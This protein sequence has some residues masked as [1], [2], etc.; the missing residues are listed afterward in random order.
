MRF[1][2]LQTLALLAARESG[3]LLRL[4]RPLRG[5]PRVL[6]PTAWDQEYSAG[7]WQFLDRLSEEAHHLVI[8]SYLSGLD[9]AERIL[10]VGC[11]EGY[12]T[13]VL[14]KFRYGQYIGIDTSSVAIAA[15]Q[16]HADAKTRFQAV[17]GDEYTTTD[18]FDAIVFNETLNYFADPVGTIEHFSKFL[19]K[20][21]VFV[22][23]LSL[24]GFRNGILK[25]GIWQDI[26]ARLNVRD[27]TTIYRPDG[28][29]WIV[30]VLTPAK[31]AQTPAPAEARQLEDA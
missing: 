11:G 17:P 28:T 22:I 13:P 27:E 10:D 31:S 7:K 3:L 25:L 24:V 21:G 14:R 26:Q 9:R 1:G 8:A 20:D 29:A 15:A 30:K 16:R 5:K 6:S 19:A 4:L 12:F 23:S 2:G 18:R